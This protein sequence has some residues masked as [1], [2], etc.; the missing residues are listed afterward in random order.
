MRASGLTLITAF[1][2]TAPVTARG[3]VLTL[4]Q[5]IEHAQGASPDI[6]QIEEQYDSAAARKRQALSP[7]EPTLSLGFNDLTEAFNLGTT[8]SNVY[9]L[10][11]TLGFPGRALL[12][13][14]ALSEQSEAV[15]AQLKAMRLQVSA[16]VK[17]AY[18]G[19]ALARKNIQ[20][21]NDQ[22][23]S[24]E[25]ILAIAKRRYET[26][27]SAQVDYLNAQV[28]LLQ[29]QNDLTDLLAAERVALTQLN[30][31]LQISPQTPLE[32]SPVEP[33][34]RPAV[35]LEVAEKK[36]LAN[37]NEI[38]VAQHQLEASGKSYA[39]AWMSLLPDFQLSAGTTFYNVPS[40]SPLSNSVGPDIA[41]PTHT[42]LAGL[43]IQIPLW[44]LFNE[45]EAITGASH[46]RAAAEANLSV[47]Y[48][49][50]RNALVTAVESINSNKIKIET[51]QR[52]MLP[53]AEQSL[54]LALVSYGAGKVDFQTLA[55]TATAR[56][57]IR[58]AYAN[59]I[60]SFLNS[61]AAYGQLI[62][63]DL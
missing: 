4:A 62:G 40:A 3:E 28:Q 45:R 6:R 44:F 21:N 7:A 49:Q 29:N 18:Y 53:M 14:A 55:D 46:D 59:A 17:Q 13:R 37:R 52:H 34:D 24:Y 57:Q 54:N 30:V 23:L 16:N 9:T 56:R 8:T 19:L 12:N 50:S 60:V 38:Q 36:M 32:V 35:E 31:L 41:Y 26:G 1:I 47:V 5:A 48:E 2:L 51:Y 58:L 63:E 15:N 43:T 11:Q 39:L 33:V 10:T 61:Y 25:R 27:N 22:R 42:Y 20:F